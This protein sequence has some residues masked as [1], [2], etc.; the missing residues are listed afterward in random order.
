MWLAHCLVV[1]L[2]YLEL[3]HFNTS[4]HLNELIDLTSEGMGKFT[5]HCQFSSS[6]LVPLKPLFVGAPTGCVGASSSCR[7]SCFVFLPLA[8][9]SPDAALPLEQSIREEG[10]ATGLLTAG[11]PVSWKRT[12]YKTTF[13]FFLILIV[14]GFPIPIIKV[15][16]THY[17]LLEN[18]ENKSPLSPEV[19]HRITP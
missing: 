7:L 18:A 19:L 16:H 17:R 5:S 12:R 11:P 4:L 15:V 1:A 6:A 13:L 14:W 3:L 10:M 8:P 9:P 2:R